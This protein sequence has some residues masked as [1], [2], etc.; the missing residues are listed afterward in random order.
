MIGAWFDR[1]FGDVVCAIAASLRFWREVVAVSLAR[2]RSSAEVQGDAF[3]AM[4]G[5][6]VGR[7]G[8]NA[9]GE[10]VEPTARDLLS[11]HCL[12]GHWEFHHNDF[13]CDHPGC[14]GRKCVTF[15][16]CDCKDGDPAD[17]LGAVTEELGLYEG[18]VGEQLD[19]AVFVAQHETYA[20]LQDRAASEVVKRT[21]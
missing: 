10:S 3:L 14:A 8:G 5:D 4:Q 19:P 16:L 20:D 18:P 13:G 7:G 12:C 1:R 21:K 15:E 17:E 11:R 6:S 2:S 9:V